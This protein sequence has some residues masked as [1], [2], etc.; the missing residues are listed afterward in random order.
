MGKLLPAS[1]MG[2]SCCWWPSPLRERRPGRGEAPWGW[3]MGATPWRSRRSAACYWWWT[4]D[5]GRA[6]GEQGLLLAALGWGKSGRHGRRQLLPACFTRGKRRAGAA[7]REEGSWSCARE[8]RR[9]AAVVCEERAPWGRKVFCCCSTGKKGV[10]T[11]C[12]GERARVRSCRILRGAMEGDV[13]GTMDR[14]SSRSSPWED[15][16]WLWLAWGRR[17][18]AEEEAVAGG[19]G[20]EKGKEFGRC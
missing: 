18:R 2:R 19:G 12:G 13:G 14:G 17:R 7:P 9:W 4:A 1:I 5:V 8:P 16:A 15:A 20:L 3:T 10:A 6:G 11:A